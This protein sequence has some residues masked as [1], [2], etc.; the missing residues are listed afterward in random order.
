MIIA[1]QRSRELG[2]LSVPAQPSWRAALSYTLMFKL[3]SAQ[4][5]SSY[6]PS[7]NQIKCVLRGT[8]G[9][10]CVPCWILGL[11]WSLT[12]KG[13]SVFRRHTIW[14][15]WH[16]FPN[17][18]YLLQSHYFQQL[19]LP[20]VSVLLCL[21]TWVLTEGSQPSFLLCSHSELLPL[22]YSVHT[23]LGNCDASYS[24]LHL[25]IWDS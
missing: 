20:S 5:F 1:Y 3:R 22:L 12:I 21:L 25:N 17:A 7:L 19:E 8:H 14:L 18:S 15:M 6:L 9:R 24:L 10:R 4:R 11:L 13:A 16:L 23:C 2:S